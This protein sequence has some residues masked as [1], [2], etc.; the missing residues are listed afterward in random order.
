MQRAIA[1]MALGMVWGRLLWVGLGPRPAEGDCSVGW[2]GGL[3][4]DGLPGW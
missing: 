4:H 3:G 1:M 2:C